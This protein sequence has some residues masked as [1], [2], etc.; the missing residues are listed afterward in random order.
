MESIIALVRNDE[1][2]AFI[3]LH[4]PFSYPGVQWAALGMMNIKDNYK[5]TGCKTDTISKPLIPA[6]F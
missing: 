3:Y 6:P 2:P 1:P 5:T 4:Q